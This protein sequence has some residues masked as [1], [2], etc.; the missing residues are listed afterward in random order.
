ML[1]P[2]I[3]QFLLYYISVYFLSTTKKHQVWTEEDEKLL[4]LEWNQTESSNEQISSEKQKLSDPQQNYLLKVENVKLKPEYPYPLYFGVRPEEKL[5]I[6]VPSILIAKQIILRVTGIE[7]EEEGNIE[8]YGKKLNPLENSS[9]GM[10]PLN[11]LSS[12]VDIKILS[13]LKTCGRA[14]GLS[15]KEAEAQAKEH[16][17]ELKLP[18]LAQ[19]E[20]GLLEPLIER[21]KVAIALMGNPKL[22]CL[23]NPL[24]EEFPDNNELIEK[25]MD[26]YIK[27]TQA[28]MVICLTSLGTALR[29]CSKVAIV[30]TSGLIRIGHPS[31][32]F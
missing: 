6:I 12:P 16:M 22:V 15:V 23:L 13:H 19:G 24:K 17:S 8:L 28:G 11:N 20:A 30:N 32:L 3:G 7:Y 31:E 10:T 29:I 9:I 2:L 18:M 14:R 4:T 26:S 27:K 1:T 21:M 25:V 5:G